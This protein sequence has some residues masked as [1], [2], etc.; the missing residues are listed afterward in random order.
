MIGN[1]LIL[2]KLGQGGMGVVFK[3]RHRRLGRVGALKIPPPSFGA[4]PRCRHAVSAARSRLPGS[5]RRAGNPFGK[6]T[7]GRLTQSGMYM[8]H[9]YFMKNS[10][11]VEAIS[12]AWV[13][14]AKCPVSK[15]RTTAFGISR[16]NASAPCGRKNGSFLP[17]AA[18]KGGL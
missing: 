12:A 16:L 18:R 5:S 3:A 11:M 8:V 2:D 14:S 10:R 13:S 6:S 4:R 17:H 9:A 1:Y 7:A 15:K